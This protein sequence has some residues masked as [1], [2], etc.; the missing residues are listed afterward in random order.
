ME[1]RPYRTPNPRS[2]PDVKGENLAYV[3]YT[4]GSTGRP[5]GVMV[6]HAG[7]ANYVGWAR[8][9]YA[10][11]AGAGTLLHGPLGFDLKPKAG[12][13]AHEVRD[14]RPATGTEARFGADR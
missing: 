5:K 1:C 3:I 4:S 10:V 6:T 7:L 12:G 9:A 2:I 14:D 8:A 13:D 11:D